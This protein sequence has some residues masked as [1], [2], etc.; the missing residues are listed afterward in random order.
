MGWMGWMGRWDDGMDG[1]M[2]VCVCVCVRTC[3]C[4]GVCV[5]E[6]VHVHVH[7]HVHVYLCACV[8]MFPKRRVDTQRR[9]LPIPHIGGGRYPH[10]AAADTP[11]RR[12]PIPELSLTTDAQPSISHFRRSLTDGLS[13]K[14]NS[15]CHATA[16]DPFHRNFLSYTDRPGK[17][18]TRQSLFL[19]SV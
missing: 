4:V 17:G 15:F 10:S 1:T 8:F 18:Y 16:G 13:Q 6:C 19:A 5:P 7:A 3:V 9:R 14:S 2:S 12:R 11:H